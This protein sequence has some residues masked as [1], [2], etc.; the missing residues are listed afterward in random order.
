VFIE[1]KLAAHLVNDQ[2]GHSRFK[3]AQAS[4]LHMRTAGPISGVFVGTVHF[5]A[6]RAIREFR[7]AVLLTQ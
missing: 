7:L 2:L 3:H 6:D 4:T 5:A 1:S